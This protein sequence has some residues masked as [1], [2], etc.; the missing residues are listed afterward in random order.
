MKSKIFTTFILFSQLQIS[1]A[2]SIEIKETEL[3]KAG[4][5][6]FCKP[7]SKVVSNSSNEQAFLQKIIQQNS[8]IETKLLRT[9]KDDK[10]F[11]SFYQFFFHR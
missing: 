8:Q 3:N 6:T 11:H 2:Q 1:F 7:V 5:I 4:K 10:S 9:I